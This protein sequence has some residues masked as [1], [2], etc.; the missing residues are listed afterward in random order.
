MHLNKPFFQLSTSPFESQEGKKTSSALT[1]DILKVASLEPALKRA[2]EP[3]P[4]SSTVLPHITL[5]IL[6]P[7]CLACGESHRWKETRL[8]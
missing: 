7:L 5:N 8:Q 3:T 4:I 1:E 6:F 2:L